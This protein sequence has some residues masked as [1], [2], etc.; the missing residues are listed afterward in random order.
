MGVEGGVCVCDICFSEI[1]VYV[2][3]IG[4]ICHARTYFRTEIQYHQ[5]LMKK[6]DSDG[7]ETNARTPEYS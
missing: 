2:L 6:S 4:S 3:Y 5:L 1:W 7:N